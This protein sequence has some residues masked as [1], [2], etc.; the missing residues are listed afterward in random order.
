MSIECYDSDCIHHYDNHPNLDGPFCDQPECNATYVAEF[1]RFSFKLSLEVAKQCSHPGDCDMDV[2]FAMRMPEVRRELIQIKPALLR[3]E[4][5]E[6]GAW[7]D[8]DL[9]DHEHNLAR[10]LWLGA[11]HIVEEQR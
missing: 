1:E 4:L 5:R 11:S 9:E 7:S 6:Y 8:E 3:A 2:A 10:I